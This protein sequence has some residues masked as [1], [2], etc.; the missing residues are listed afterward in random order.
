MESL[1]YSG[2]LATLIASSAEERRSRITLRK[3]TF[4]KRTGLIQVK[5]IPRELRINAGKCFIWNAV[6]YISD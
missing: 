3:G 5:N 1:Q 4:K 2:T 6:C